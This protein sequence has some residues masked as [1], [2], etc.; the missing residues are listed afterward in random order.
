MEPRACTVAATSL[1]IVLY[2]RQTAE[3]AKLA[4]WWQH[5]DNLRNWGKW[6]R[7]NAT[8]ELLSHK[9]SSSQSTQFTFSCWRE[10]QTGVRLS[11]LNWYLCNSLLI[12]SFSTLHDCRMR[13]NLGPNMRANSCGTP[14]GSDLMLSCFRFW[15]DSPRVDRNKVES[16]NVTSFQLILSLVKSKLFQQS[17]L[18]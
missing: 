8:V 1:W 16:G 9:Q 11:L 12:S 3:L 7:T 14:T 4:C 6:R 10:L 13:S 15:H 18:I 5:L 2:K 17:H